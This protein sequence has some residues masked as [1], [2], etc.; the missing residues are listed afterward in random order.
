MVLR[1]NLFIEGN[2]R[3]LVPDIT[4][5][6]LDAYRAPY[7]DPE[8]RRPML[9]WSREFPLDG[10]P[11]DVVARVVAYGEWMGQSV[12]VPKLLMTVT[13]ALGLGAPALIGW[14]KDNISALEIDELGAA[15]HHAT[16]QI[17]VAIGE[18]VARWL[19]KL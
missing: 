17:P 7:P 1:E 4:E 5:Q 15:N 11:A 9:Q 16:E 3:R 18:S 12:D 13:P 2:L 8:S 14:A 6:D 19:A 10:E